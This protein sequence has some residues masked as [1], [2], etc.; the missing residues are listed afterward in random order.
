MLLPPVTVHYPHVE[1]RPDVLAA[2]PFISGTRIP[3]RR[4]WSWHRSGTTVETLIARY[5]QLGPAKIM[6]ALAFAYDNAAVVE[7]DLARERK[8]LEQEAARV[9]ERG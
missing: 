7:A 8:L 5:P 3:V 6:S 2:S 9:G 1:V 4:L